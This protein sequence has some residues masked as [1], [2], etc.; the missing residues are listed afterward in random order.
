LGLG[1]GRNVG[2]RIVPVRMFKVREGGVE[3]EEGGTI[4]EVPEDGKEGIILVAQRMADNVSAVFLF[5]NFF[6][7]PRAPVVLI[8]ET[9]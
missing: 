6:L 2:G 3:G 4:G 9:R 1:W 8:L 5:L 7:A